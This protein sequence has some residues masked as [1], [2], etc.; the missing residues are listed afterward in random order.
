MLER[1]PTAFDDRIYGADWRAWIDPE[2]PDEIA[3]TTLLLD[4]HLGTP[5][6][7]KAALIVDG[8]PISYGELTRLVATV[9]S[10]LAARGVAPDDRI[11]LFGTDSLDY[12]AMWLGAVRAGAIPAVVSDLYKARELLHFLRDTAARLC[13]IDAEQIGK[14]IEI[15]DALPPSLHTIIIRGEFPALPG[16][17]RELTR[18]EGRKVLPFAAIRDGHATTTPPLLRHRNDITYMFFSGG[19]T[20]TAKG[21]T[22]LAHDFVL[23]SERHGRFW[24]YRETDVVFATSKKYFTHGLWP[25]LLIP[26]YWGATAVLMR[27]PPVPEPVL[28]T[29][30]D[31]GVTKLITVPTVLKNILEHVRQSGTKPNFPALDFVA[32][33]SER[34]PP[35]IF[36]RF[37]EQFGVELFDSIG[38]SE[39]TYEWIANRQKE[40]KRG[41][42]GKPIFGYEVRLM[43]ADHG[44]VT[45]PNVPGEAWIKSKTAC[46]FYWRKYDKSR[47]TFIGEWTRT[48]DNLYFDEDGFFWFS[49]RNDDMFKVK[50]LWVAPIEIEAALTGHP[51]VHEAAVVSFTDRD[52]FTKPKAFVVLRQG[53]A[54]SE[55]LIGEL[56]AAVRPLGGYK[57]PERFEFVDELP[58]TTLMKIDR[59]SLRQRG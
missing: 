33:A 11:L 38:S 28:R 16:E 47:E 23:V 2:V 1:V 19:T 45:E 15:A 43:S 59:R 30:A 14:L 48:G 32:S 44:D 39:I 35:E 52:G 4:R 50:G 56:C 40:F 36:S 58:R 9:S 41:S 13:F 31:A 29:L 20:G 3:P 18:L 8:A 24:Q 10:E 54:Q 26:L 25:G 17:G 12:V 5:V 42:L 53:H 57:V 55:A 34:I 49:G 37:Y 27:R 22:H 6:E 51:A 46:F 7:R 21:I